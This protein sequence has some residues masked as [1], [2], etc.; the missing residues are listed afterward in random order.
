M[1][2]LLTKHKHKHKHQDKNK[3]LG[4]QD[5]EYEAPRPSRTAKELILGT[6]SQDV[7]ARRRANPMTDGLNRVSNI[8]RPTEKP[9]SHRKIYKRE[10]KMSRKREKEKEI[11]E[12]VK[13]AK[14]K[15]QQQKK[16]EAKLLKEIKEQQEIRNMYLAKLH[17]KRNKKRKRKNKNDVDAKSRAKELNIDPDEYEYSDDSDSK[18]YCKVDPKIDGQLWCCM[19]FAPSPIVQQEEK[20][21]VIMRE[22]LK[23]VCEEFDWSYKEFLERY[24]IFKLD[25]DH[26]IREKLTD[27]FKDPYF[28]GAVK[29]R[30]AF[31]SEK[32]ARSYAKKKLGPKDPK[33][34]VFIGP[35]GFWVPYDA[36]KRDVDN[37]ET[38]NKQLN[39]IVKKSTQN[40]EKASK[41][42]KMRKEIQME[43]A[44]DIE[45]TQQKENIRAQREGEAPRNIKDLKRKE[46]LTEEDMIKLNTAVDTDVYI[47]PKPKRKEQL[48]RLHISP[49]LN[50][51]SDKDSDA[52]NSENS[53]SDCSVH[54]VDSE[55]NPT[56]PTTMSGLY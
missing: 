37:Y 11:E 8:V 54:T 21:A 55:I 5:L 6:V 28:E 41:F 24:E 16:N 53:D 3:G 2:S 25:H 20:A 22:F 30:G 45:Q 39:T 51:D 40:K 44:A 29:F 43:K 12:K 7:W 49:E 35:V 13:L 42:W 36:R 52:E 34:S 1:N 33:Y 56:G 31:P 32:K 46:E 15:R 10:Q 17:K 26:E 14:A 18:D 48:K 47:P 50:E 27:H 19:S 38:A 9:I 4:T 23:E